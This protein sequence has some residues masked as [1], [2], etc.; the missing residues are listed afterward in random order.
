MFQFLFHTYLYHYKLFDSYRC[1]IKGYT[2][3]LVKYTNKLWGCVA[4]HCFF[5]NVIKRGKFDFVNRNVL[6]G[7]SQM[8]KLY[9]VQS[10]LDPAHTPLYWR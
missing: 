5:T 2:I 10:C 9:L 8:I 3:L 1:E 7:G 6:V 4:A